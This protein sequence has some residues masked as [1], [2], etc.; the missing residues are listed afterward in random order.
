MCALLRL[1][2]STKDLAELT[3]RSPRT[4]EYTRTNIRRKMGLSSTDNLLTKLW[5][6][7]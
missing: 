7:E 1:Q 4:I 2:L 6:I 5:S 3:Q